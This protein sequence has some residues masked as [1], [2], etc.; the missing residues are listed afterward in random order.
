M[1]K[2]LLVS[3]LLATVAIPAWAARDPNPKRGVQKAKRAFAAFCLAYAF[4]VS[5]VYHRL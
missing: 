3:V 1:G 5:I 2:L 4:Y